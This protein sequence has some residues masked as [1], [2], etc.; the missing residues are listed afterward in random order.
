MTTE[1]RRVDVFTAGCPL[2]DEAVKLV[3]SLACPS[4]DIRLYDLRAGCDRNECREK[5]RDY[6]ISAVPAIAVDGVTLDCCR[7]EPITADRLRAAGIGR[8]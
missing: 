7:R 1:K 2:C 8:P 3:K 4:C 5:I 6:G